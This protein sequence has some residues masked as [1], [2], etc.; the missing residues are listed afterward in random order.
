V[1]VA[2][3]LGTSFGKVF[4]WDGPEVEKIKHVVEP[5]VKYLFVSHSRQRDIP[6]MDGVDRIDH[7]NMLTFSLTNRLWARFNQGRTALPEDADVEPVAAPTVG[8][9]REFGRLRFAVS[10]DVDQERTSGDRLSDLDI[11]MRVMPRDY[12]AFE[13][14][15][16]VHPNSGRVSQVTALF[17]IFDPRPITRRVLDVDFMRPN[18]LDLSYRFIGKTVDSLLADNANLLFVDPRSPKLCGPPAT[19][20]GDPSFDPRCGI[21]KSVMGLIGIR[22]ILHLTDHLMFIYDSNYNVLKGGFTTNRG[23]LKILSGCECWTLTLSLNKL[24]N[25]NETRFNFNFN[26]LGLG[27]Q[28]KQGSR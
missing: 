7:R 11:N 23:S 22:S 8:D 10:Y 9:T 14:G 25:P 6:I 19:P 5:E 20:S 13:S 12:L 16:G 1:E 17:S 2:G 28:A 15:T 4:S 3:N 26:L 21:E 27:S 18:S 24:T